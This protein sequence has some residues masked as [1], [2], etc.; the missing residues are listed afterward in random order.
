M[1]SGLT[2]CLL[3]VGLALVASTKAEA[4]TLTAADFA[5]Y[6]S[7]PCP[8]AGSEQN[9]RSQL[10]DFYEAVAAKDGRFGFP[11][12]GSTDASQRY[13]DGGALMN[14]YAGD[15][16]VGP[17]ADVGIIFV[18]GPAFNCLACFLETK[19]EGSA[20]NLFNRGNWHGTDAT[21]GSRFFPGFDPPNGRGG[22]LGPQGRGNGPGLTPT[23]PTPEPG[24]M[25]LVMVG[26]A[27]LVGP[28]R[29]LLRERKS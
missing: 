10:W 15:R 12:I 25:G 26:L 22:G 14:N 18:V 1:R 17:S 6:Q 9:S 3:T 29:R 19:D 28:V 13:D 5:C 24:T 11:A 8:I 21:E 4:L 2:A 27:L 7:G 16:E 20:A 23:S